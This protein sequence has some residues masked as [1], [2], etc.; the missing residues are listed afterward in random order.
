MNNLLGPP[1]PKLIAGGKSYFSTA[2]KQSAY[3]AFTGAHQAMTSKKPDGSSYNPIP[4]GMIMYAALSV[5]CI[6]KRITP[7][8]LEELISEVSK[9]LA[10]ESDA[11][12]PKTDA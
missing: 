2:E 12:P 5:L 4:Y 9:L 3:M 11:Q 8:K 1:K 6:R 10:S 7:E